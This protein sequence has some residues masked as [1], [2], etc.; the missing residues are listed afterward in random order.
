MRKIMASLDVGTNS[1]KLIV[2]E[3]ISGKLNILAVSETAS[4][5]V[6]RGIIINKD[7]VMEGV[8]KVLK[9]V[10]T[11]IGLPIKKMVVTVPS[12]D[13]A[14]TINAAVININNEEH[15]V[16]G[17]DITKVL[18]K[19][20]RDMIPDNMELVSATP[21]VY[22][23]DE[24][25]KVVNPIN[26][27]ANTL[28]VKTILTMAPKQTIYPIIEILESL[29]IEV[30]DIAYSAMASYYE[31]Q[32]EETNKS[33]GAVIN[34]GHSST[35]IAIFNKGVMSNIKKLDLG[36]VNIDNDIAYMYKI[37]VKDA[38]N[39]KETLALASNDLA[40]PKNKVKVTNKDG[41]EV[42]ISQINLSKIV[43]SRIEEILTM[44]KKEINL[45]TKKEISYIIVTGGMIELTDFSLISEEIFG[46]DV[47][48]G[49]IKEVGVRHNKYSAAL[50]LIKWYHHNNVVKDK[51]YSIFSIEEQ[52]EFSGIDKHIAVNDNTVL[53]KIFSYFFNS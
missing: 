39:L 17:S 42:E 10:E 6:K 15:I 51:D 24:D 37:P 50:G 34:L 26:A 13:V 7:E 18:A 3:M 53:G 49:D 11:I 46:H 1:I 9:D 23:L 35:E 27:V 31:F 41:E 20:A 8:S 36:G 28:G 33:T 21:I 45:L 22:V 5:G 32:T 43:R 29:G 19:S 40:S 14:L 47:S 4:K 52:E 48:L 30:L 2:G 12:N 38:H 25:K 16:T 44:V